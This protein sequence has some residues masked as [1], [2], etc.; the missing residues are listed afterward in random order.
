MSVEN[1]NCTLV[2]GIDIDLNRVAVE[3][4]AT[5]AYEPGVFPAAIFR[6]PK[7]FPICCLV[8]STGK[9]VITGGVTEAGAKVAARWLLRGPLRGQCEEAGVVVL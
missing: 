7:M 8:F 9:V 6:N 4:P 2:V 3:N 5:C 1:I